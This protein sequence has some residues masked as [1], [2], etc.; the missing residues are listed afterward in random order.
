MRGAAVRSFLVY[1]CRAKCSSVREWQQ[2]GY[3][4]TES[5]VLVT[6]C[7]S[8][9][10]SQQITSQSKGDRQKPARPPDFSAPYP[11]G[12]TGQWD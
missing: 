11:V 2:G 6:H 4:C 10:R 9:V 8:L 12:H 1:G 7:R 3:G 5:E